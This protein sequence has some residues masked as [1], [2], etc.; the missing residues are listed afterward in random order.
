LLNVTATVPW[1][2]PEIENGK[3]NELK[4]PNVVS[5]PN[6]PANSDRT[7][8]LIVELEAEQFDTEPQLS[9]TLAVVL[10]VPAK[11]DAV[12]SAIDKALAQRRKSKRSNSL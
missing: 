5:L 12:L 6:Q 3:C 1:T 10:R 4:L 2:V 7:S 8:K 9:E 11:N